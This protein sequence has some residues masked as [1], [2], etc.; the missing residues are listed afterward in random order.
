MSVCAREKKDRNA[1]ESMCVSVCVR[2]KKDRN[3]G[4]SMCVSVCV[5]EKKDR[6]AGESMSVSVCA[7]ACVL[8][9]PQSFAFCF[10]T[11]AQLELH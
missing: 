3:A 1:G 5:R 6:N 11:M 10:P 7:R 8:S 9:Y 2:E 4:E